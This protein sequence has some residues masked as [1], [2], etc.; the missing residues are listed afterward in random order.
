M[1]PS[2]EGGGG[3][4]PVMTVTGVALGPRVSRAR[5]RLPT[6][7]NRGGPPPVN[8]ISIPPP[9]SGGIAVRVTSLPLCDTNVTCSGES[10][11][12]S[13]DVGRVRPVVPQVPPRAEATSSHL[14]PGTGRARS[15]WPVGEPRCRC[16][17]YA[18]KSAVTWPLKS[19]LEMPERW[20]V[21]L[22][23]S[24][25]LFIASYAA[26]RKAR[27]TTPTKSTCHRDSPGSS[28]WAE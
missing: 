11:L 18:E 4:P 2:H 23:G 21:A 25:S 22:A 24:H 28:D 20:I 6:R 8:T 1:S 17:T 12:A 15:T 19:S 5:S 7:H 13:K 26:T 16:W 14:E 3:A 9:C 27:V 10:H